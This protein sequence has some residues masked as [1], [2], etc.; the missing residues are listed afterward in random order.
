MSSPFGG[1]ASV[2]SAQMETCMKTAFR[3][4]VYRKGPQPRI[5]RFTVARTGLTGRYRDIYLGDY[6]LWAMTWSFLT[7][8][9]YKMYFYDNWMK[10]HRIYFEY[11][12]AY[13]DTSSKFNVARS[14]WAGRYPL[15]VENAAD[16]DFEEYCVN[17]ACDEVP[18]APLVDY[19]VKW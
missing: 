14:L 16:I 7:T 17:R 5:I 8:A 10:S 4:A 12:I 18:P 9:A 1:R 13:N 6:L 2:L 19:D 3:N 15:T 11:N